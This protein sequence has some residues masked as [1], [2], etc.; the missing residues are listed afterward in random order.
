MLQALAAGVVNED[1]FKL[2]DGS[3]GTNWLGLA[4]GQVCDG[5]FDGVKRA[6]KVSEWM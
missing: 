5:M 6:V 2:L 3:T 1:A 4:P